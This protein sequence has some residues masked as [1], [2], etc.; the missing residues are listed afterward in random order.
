MIKLIQAHLDTSIT[1][2]TFIISALVIFLGLGDD[3]KNKQEQLKFVLISYSVTISIILFSARIPTYIFGVLILFFFLGGLS[4]SI[5]D[6][7]ELEKELNI[8]QLLFYSSLSWFFITNTFFLFFSVL[9][10]YVIKLNY[11]ISLIAISL[12]LIIQYL[13]IIKDYFEINSYSNT[14]SNFGNINLYAKNNKHAED[15]FDNEFL[16]DKLQLVAFVLY[17]EDRYLLDR[18]KCHITFKNLLDSKKDPIIFKGKITYEQKSCLDKYKRG[19]STIEQ[20]LIRQHSIGDN[21][22]RYKYRRKLFFDWIY[23][24]FFSKAIC[25]RK[26]RVYGKN[27]KIAKTELIWNLKMMFLY[28]YFIDVLE[29][30]SDK[31]ELIINMSNQSRVSISVYKKMFEIFED[32]SEKYKVMEKIQQSMQNKYNFY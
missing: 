26:S 20:Q 1:I 16:N 27:K 7:F 6:N 28:N 9:I 30:P 31:N 5:N 32:S 2:A 23:A 17:V 8:P 10:I 21:S 19:Y 4:Y 3:K 25:N 11:Y 12:S 24:P 15:F 29:N 14:F 22:Y 13:S 18:K